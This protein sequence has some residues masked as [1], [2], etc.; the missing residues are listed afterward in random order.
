MLCPDYHSPHA[1]LEQ[2]WTEAAPEGRTRHTLCRQ[3]LLTG[4]LEQAM[5][6]MVLSLRRCRLVAQG[7]VDHVAE[8]DEPADEDH[9]LPGPLLCVFLRR[10]ASV[11]IR[12]LLLPLQHLFRTSWVLCAPQLTGLLHIPGLQAH[13]GKN[14]EDQG[15]NLSTSS[16]GR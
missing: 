9:R 15:T 10:E 16:Q 4:S 6:L 12:D 14:K 1:A 11:S 13:H 7:N 5:P 2:P 8:D 3:I